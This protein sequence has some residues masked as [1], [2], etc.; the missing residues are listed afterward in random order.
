V[1][2]RDSTRSTTRLPAGRS[3]GVVTLFPSS[4]RGFLEASHLE[5][6]G[7]HR[8]SV[9]VGSPTVVDH[10]FS[11]DPAGIGTRNRVT[12]TIAGRETEVVTAAGVFSQDRID[13]GT[14]V[15]VKARIRLPDEGDVLDLGCGWGPIALTM[16]SWSPRARVWA[17]DVNPRAVELTAENARLLGLTGIRAVA[18]DGVPPGL[19][20]AGIWS[21]PPIR[22]GKEPLR[23]LLRTWL[24]RLAPGAEAFLVVQKHLGGDSVHAWLAQEF[25]EERGW[26]VVRH[27]SAK[28]YRVL[29]VT[30]PASSA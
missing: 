26:E 21:N 1:P 12:V 24:P 20:F 10:Y 2:A 18:P 8:D 25:G 11:D 14:R 23:E 5:R 22:I 29:R 30:R 17:V 4:N 19:S 15:L 27:G 9:T 6:C 16:A 13:L 3:L 7:L 28:G